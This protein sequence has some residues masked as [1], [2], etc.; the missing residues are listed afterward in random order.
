MKKCRFLD[1]MAER[2]VILEADFV[3]LTSIQHSRYLS[4]SFQ[5]PLSF[6][7][8]WLIKFYHFLSQEFSLDPFEH[9]H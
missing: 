8:L 5:T 2:S 3:S 1:L 9:Q 6:R 7:N 4:Q